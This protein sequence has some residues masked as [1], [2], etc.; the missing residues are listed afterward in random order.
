MIPETTTS[1]SGSGG[2]GGGDLGP[3]GVDCSKFQTPQCMAAVCNTGQWAGPL[4]TCIVV[5]ADD[6]TKCDDGKFCTTDDACS[7]GACVGAMENTCGFPASP[8][9]SVICYEDLKSCDTAPVNEGGDC[10]PTDLCQENGVCHIGECIGEPKDC[11]FSPLNECNKTACDPGTGKCV[12]TPDPD[13]EDAPCLLTGDLCK[14]NKTCSNGVCGG[15]VPMDCSALD[16]GCEVGLCNPATGICG[17]TP[18]PVGTVCSEGVSECQVGA[19][20]DKGG[21]VPSAAQDGIACNDHNACTKADT[22]K[23]GVCSGGSIA[24]CV[25]YLRDGFENCSNGWTFGGDWQCGKPTNVGPPAAHS[26]TNV[27]ATQIAGYYSVNQSFSTT[28]ADSPPVDL[29]KATTPQ[30]SFWAWDHTEGATFDG[31]NLKVSTDGGTTFTEVTTVNPPYP[32]MINGQPAWGGDHSAEGW[33]NYVADLKDY[34]GQKVILRF[35][36][37]SDGATVFPGVY[38]DDVVVSEPPQI[39]LYITTP[40]P[41]QD[42]YAGMFYSTPMSKIGGSTPVWSLIPVTNAGWLSIDSATGVVSGTPHAPMDLGPVTFTVHVEE[43][44]LP[45]NYDEKTF[46]LNVKPDIFYTSFEDACPGNWTLTGD[47]QCGVPMNVGPATAYVGTQCIGTQIAANYHDNQTYAA[48]TATS[49]DIDLTGAANP[50]LTFRMWVD[51]EGS[52][53]D[54]FNLNVSTDG[55]AT[56]SVVTNVV[57]AY[58]LTVATK[59]AWGGH[60]AALGW[61][62]VKVDMSAYVNQVVR[63]RFA[64]RSDS[65]GTFPGVYIDDILVN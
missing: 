41:L 20:D 54:G 56:Y 34:I 14:V 10:T 39:P 23:A 48:T 40:T 65:S 27:L 6:G 45:S 37:R 60:Q 24:G 61:Q 38:I 28:V 18:A 1:T 17:P 12:G 58:P 35:A 43:Q 59:P 25:L 51:T 8:C 4:N 19:C 26:G 13:K 36:F 47:W 22:C 55:G 42:V 64:F 53:Y 31:W 2:T 62:L 57:P 16:V 21:C 46:T 50:T 29:T 30:I 3:C 63:L 52:T 32:L 11:A 15:G 33:K 44:G 9:V 49:P 7:N 5:P